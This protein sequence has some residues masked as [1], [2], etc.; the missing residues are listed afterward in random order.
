LAEAVEL[1]EFG[2]FKKG[3]VKEVLT[4]VSRKVVSR[5]AIGEKS[6]VSH[7]EYVAHVRVT[8]E[9]LACVALTDKEYPGRVAFDLIQE[10]L[11]AFN[12]QSK[13]WSKLTADTL[14]T[15]PLLDSLL[16]KYQK[17]QEADKLMKIQKDVDE[18]KQI[19]VKNIVSTSHQ[20]ENNCA[21][22]CRMI[23]WIIMRN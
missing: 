1:T 22:Q 9:K 4:F 23:C 21:S 3:S 2:Y 11:A 20:C 15:V 5:S 6:S 12:A 19:M 16:K 13:D 7:E 8:N 17:P 14:I 10:A 18:V